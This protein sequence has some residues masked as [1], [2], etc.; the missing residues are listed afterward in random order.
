MF[1][2]ELTQ[3]SMNNTAP[4]PKMV[5]LSLLPCYSNISM[6]KH[7]LYALA[8]GQVFLYLYFLDGIYFVEESIQAIECP[9]IVKTVTFKRIRTLEHNFIIGFLFI[10]VQYMILPIQLWKISFFFLPI[11]VSGEWNV[12]KRPT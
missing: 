7:L 6:W 10:N 1:G 2:L 4:W 11:I 3:R 12:T 5:F 9:S 8:K